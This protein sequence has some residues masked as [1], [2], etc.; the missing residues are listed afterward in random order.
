MSHRLLAVEVLAQL[1][2]GAQAAGPQALDA[3]QGDQAL[4]KD[5]FEIEAAWRIVMPRRH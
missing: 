1:Q 4:F 2:T 3:V 5:R